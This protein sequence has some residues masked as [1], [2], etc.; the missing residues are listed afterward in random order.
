LT[1]LFEEPRAQ[2][3]QQKGSVTV[4]VMLKLSQLLDAKRRESFDIMGDLS[5]LSRQ[6]PQS[7]LTASTPVSPA[8]SLFSAKGHTRFSSSASSLVST[9]GHGNSMDIPSR[10]PLTGVKEEEPFGSPARD[11]E[12][13]YFRTLPLFPASLPSLFFFVLRLGVFKE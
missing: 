9:P 3:L 12:E 5:P 7:P 13:E 11:L 2:N 6:P 4:T 10:N 8:V 1:N